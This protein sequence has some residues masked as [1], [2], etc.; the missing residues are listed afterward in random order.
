MFL[1]F[2]LGI[3]FVVALHQRRVTDGMEGVMNVNSSRASANQNPSHS[4]IIKGFLSGEMS[5]RIEQLCGMRDVVFERVRRNCAWKIE[6]RCADE[7]E[8]RFLGRV[9]G[10]CVSHYVHLIAHPCFMIYLCVYL[11]YKQEMRCS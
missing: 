5:L 11:L 10:F 4:F 7:V 8:R 2:I 3:E 9:E 1:I 6:G